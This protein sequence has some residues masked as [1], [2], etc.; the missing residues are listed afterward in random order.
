MDKSKK[1]VLIT[2]GAGFIGSHLADRLVNNNINTI[3]YDNFS[4]GNKKNLVNCLKR[5]NFELIV[6]DLNNSKKFLAFCLELKQ[7]FT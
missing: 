7:F 4:T 3:V 2:G 1:S 6:G 5:T